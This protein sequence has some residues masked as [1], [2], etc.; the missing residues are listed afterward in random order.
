MEISPCSFCKNGIVLVNNLGDSK[1]CEHCNGT[2][3]CDFSD[4]CLEGDV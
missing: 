4:C 3:F 2:T 1:I